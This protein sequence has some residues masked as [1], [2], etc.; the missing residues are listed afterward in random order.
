MGDG[1]IDRNVEMQ[2]NFGR[3]G[4]L[5]KI[6]RFTLAMALL[7]ALNTPASLAQTEG[8][9]IETNANHAVAAIQDTETPAQRDVRMSWWRE[10]RFGMFIHWGL[11]AVP[12]GTWDN[13]RVPSIGEWIM[14]NASIPVADYKALARGF[15]P[16]AFN[17]HDI[18]ALAKAAGMK[19]IV[20]TAKHH[21][22]FAMFDSKADG[23]NIV[24][25][26]PFRRDPIRELA[27]ECKKQGVRLGFYYSQD[28]D[29]T[30]PGG[31][32]YLKGNHHSPSHHWDPAQDGNFA[33]YL[34]S[35]AIPQ[36][37]ELLSDYGDFPAVIWFDTPTIDMTPALAGEIVAL[38]NQYPKLIWNNRL[39]GG[40]KGDT[41][42]PEQYIPAKGYPGRDWE[43]CMTMNR[44]WGFKSYDHDFKSAKTLLRNLIDIASKGGNYLLN[45]GPDSKGNVP[46][47]EIERLHQIGNWLA[48]NGEAVYGTSAT[49]FGPEAGSFSAGQRDK[50]G[51]PKFVPTWNWR[52]TTAANRIY[53]ELFRWPGATFHLGRVPRNIA[54][55]F[56][57]ADP[58]KKQLKIKTSASGVDIEL[59]GQA[60]DP[61]ATVLV[62]ETT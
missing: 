61:I 55:A 46:P 27:E 41:D 28:Q 20:I 14:N 29:W 32:A 56:L 25:A 44:T 52:S 42:T 8:H 62:L 2:R 58:A 17:A 49:L 47:E 19:Y 24:A 33:T 3:P 54:G 11:Y 9:Q 53:I 5:L 23:F 22:G 57:L 10:A 30:A 45:I 36:L 26:T 51:N 6:Y 13:K 4:G 35:K 12:A 18:V 43:A 50:E 60:T 1:P 31:A 37:K 34:H 16:R 15:E 48:I 21:D 40:Y 38:L 39:G 7:S 59:P